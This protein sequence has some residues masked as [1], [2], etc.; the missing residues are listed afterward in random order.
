VIG[1]TRL[2]PRGIA[3]VVE[4]GVTLDDP[5]GVDLRSGGDARREGDLKHHA[6]ALRHWDA[7]QQVRIE[8]RLVRG[9][10]WIAGSRKGDGKTGGLALVH[11]L[12]SIER[13]QDADGRHLGVHHGGA[14]VLLN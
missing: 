7:F 1:G 4:V 9:R 5:I 6:R 10:A 13:L 3:V 12:E 14:S 8:P 11:L 2:A